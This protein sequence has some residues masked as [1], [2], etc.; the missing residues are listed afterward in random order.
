MQVAGRWVT[1]LH[2]AFAYDDVPQCRLCPTCTA[3]GGEC[4]FLVSERIADSEA[5]L[6]QIGQAPGQG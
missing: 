5:P 1:A 6:Y 3:V 4:M 2:R